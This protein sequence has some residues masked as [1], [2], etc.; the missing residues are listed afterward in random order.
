MATKGITL[1]DLIERFRCEDKCRDYLAHLRWPDGVACVRCGSVRV[2]I[3]AQR[4]QFECGDCR[5]QFSV[6]AGTL[7]HDS[8]LPLWK[9]FLAVYMMVESRK[10]IS[11][12]QLKRTL[13]VTYKTA[14]YLCH[15]I[16]AAMKDTS[17]QP[18]DGVVEV[19]E[20]FL[21]MKQEG[22][23]TL[24]GAVERDG[25]VRIKHVPNRS[26]KQVQGF[27]DENI[28]DDAEAM[29]T[30]KYRAYTTAAKAKGLTH[31]NVRKTGVQRDWVNGQVHTN[32]IEGV[33]SLF[34]RS[35]VGSYHKLSTKHLPAYLDEMEFRY[36]N[37]DNPYL[38]RDALIALLTAERITYRALVD[39][40]GEAE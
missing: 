26:L 32:T 3:I 18:L 12:N 37:R 14:W 16:R 31:A 28:S 8:K 29:Y 21:I 9:W 15:R 20:A 17:V 34:K 39:K 1:P 2:S 23:V 6:R 10:G 5:Y 11:A 40:A 38:F 19:D 25:E 7:F 36:N 33:W 13:G 35:V 30:D 22:R 4:N 24:I 27:V